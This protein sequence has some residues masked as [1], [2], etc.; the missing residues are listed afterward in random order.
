MMY[1]TRHGQ[2]DWNAVNRVMGAIDMPLNT[3][4]L[5][6][7]KQKHND[8]LEANIDLIICSP[9]L[10]AKQTADIIN[11]DRNIPIIFDSRISERDFGE[12]EGKNI[13]EFD[14]SSYWNYYQNQKYN[15]SE[16]IQSFFK[17]VYEFL[18]D[19][20][21]KYKDKNVLLVTHGGVGIA[22]EC[23]FKK[24][25]PEGYL[26]NTDMSLDNCEIKKYEIA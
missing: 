13:D 5:E 4:G 6:Q 18:D 26:I 10:R 25:I 19:V 1:L 21:S 20:I 15:N 12:F 3:I 14:F 24:E 17:R 7:A 9:L 8:L 2:T 22:T 23:Y 16:N 11:K